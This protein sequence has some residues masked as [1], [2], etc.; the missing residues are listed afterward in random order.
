MKNLQIDGRAVNDLIVEQIGIIGE[1]LDLAYYDFI[2]AEKVVAYVHPG[3]K[4]ASLVGFNQASFDHQVAKDIAMQVA[5]MD[6]VAIDKGDV[7]PER[8]AKELEIGKEQARNEGKPEEMLDKIAQGKL[9]KFYKENTLVNQDF[10]KDNKM[11]V[12]QY[13]QKTNKNF[14]TLDKGRNNN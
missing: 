3:N 6:P 2:E 8:I 4:L 5:A 14:K 7:T 13:L 12:G 11:T 9:N 10:V 1:K